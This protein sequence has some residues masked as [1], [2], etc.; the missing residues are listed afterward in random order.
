MKVS[1]KL[2]DEKLIPQ[3]IQ[4]YPDIQNIEVN[5]PSSVVIFSKSD[6]L[7]TLTS[8]TKEFL[9]RLWDNLG[10]GYTYCDEGRT[11]NERF[12]KEISEHYK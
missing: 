6:P 11:D 5:I 1:M 8:E 2:K 3:Y 12:E 10:A 4:F 7:G 9:G